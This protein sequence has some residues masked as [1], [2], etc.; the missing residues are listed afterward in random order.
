MDALAISNE[1]GYDENDV[2]ESKEVFLDVA[3]KIKVHHSTT[4][5]N[6]LI[7]YDIA[8]KKYKKYKIENDLAK[9]LHF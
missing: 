6:T 1:E 9:S 5:P 2:L 4:K 8:Q 3:G 7:P